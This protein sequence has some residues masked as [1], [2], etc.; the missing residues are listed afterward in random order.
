M[1]LGDDVRVHFTIHSLLSNSKYYLINRITFGQD[2]L[3]P[4]SF[5][6]TLASRTD[7]TRTGVRGAPHLDVL[8][9]LGDDA[10]YCRVGLLQGHG[11]VRHPRQGVPVEL[12][13]FRQFIVDAHLMEQRRR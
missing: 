9:D 5:K 12:L 7:H 11:A 8:L 13:F 2:F 3:A 4:H 6:L 10:H 1:K